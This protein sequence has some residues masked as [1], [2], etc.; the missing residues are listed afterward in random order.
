LQISIFQKSITGKTVCAETHNI[1]LDVNGLITI[2]IGTGAIE[3]GDFLKIEWGTDTYFI[4]SETDPLEGI[5][6]TFSG[7]SQ[8]LSVAYALYAKTANNV[9]NYKIGDFVYEGIIFDVDETKILHF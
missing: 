9:P 4:K 5:N 1:N 6:Y 2:E 3:S 8:L 7:T